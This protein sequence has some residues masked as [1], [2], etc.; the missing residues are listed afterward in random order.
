MKE[1]ELHKE[2]QNEYLKLLNNNS[3]S[4]D[5]NACNKYEQYDNK[6]DQNV[7]DSTNMKEIK[8]ISAIYEKQGQSP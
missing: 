7:I 1:R 3:P 8:D 4:K 6:T 5:I 2:L